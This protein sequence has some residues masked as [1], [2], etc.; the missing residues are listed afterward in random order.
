ML[1]E[2]RSWY[3]VAQG[4]TLSSCKGT[5]EG[6]QLSLHQ[7]IPAFLVQT[8]ACEDLTDTHIGITILCVTI[9]EGQPVLPWV[10]LSQL[11]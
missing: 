7:N 9:I 3:W 5:H 10:F 11:P 4:L 1:I 2:W 8:R 6:V